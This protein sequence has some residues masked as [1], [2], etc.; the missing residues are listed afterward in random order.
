[1]KKLIHTAVVTLLA[2]SAAQAQQAVQW[3]VEDGGNGHW[4][5]VCVIPTGTTW[6]QASDLAA[7]RGGHLATVT[8]AGEASTVR[9]V[10]GTSGPWFVASPAWGSSAGPW[11]GGYQDDVSGAW[12]WV[13]GEP[14]SFAAWCANQPSGNAC[15]EAERFLHVKLGDYCDETRWWGDISGTAVCLPEL[16]G[17]V[18]MLME[19]DADCNGDGIV[20]YGQ[21]HDGTLP[22][23]NGNNMPDCCERDE[24][25]V[26]GNYPV[27]WRVEDGGNGHWYGFGVIAAGDASWMQMRDRAVAMGGHL[28]TLSSAAEDVFAFDLWRSSQPFQGQDMM[29]GPLGYFVM[30]GG[31]WQSVNGEPMTYTNWRPA[32]TAPP[33][34]PAPDNGN[35]VHR[36]ATWLSSDWGPLAGRWEDWLD[37]ELGNPGDPISPFMLEWDADCN[38]DG[39]VDY[40]QIL[41]RQLPDSNG[42]SVPDICQFPNCSDADLFRD[43][44]VNGADLGILL[45]QWGPNTPLTVSDINGDGSVNG[46]DLG[47]L[48]S[49]WGACP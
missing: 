13:T 30:P 8:S 6:H 28:L 22:D 27:Q 45:S 20:D 49:F 47:L 48:L 21:C 37:S 35:A 19:F 34:P 25:C 4:Y 23:Y 40:G 16:S 31:T 39:L 11:L 36:F 43:F 38:S 26:V 44:N 3:R 32:T 15:A 12:H 24:A 1:M 2:T 42:D 5:Q 18:G 10:V 9:D 33:L 29:A 46:A 17:L 7:A 41:Q 14:W